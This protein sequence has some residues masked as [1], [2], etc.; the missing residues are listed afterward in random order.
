MSLID[1]LRA[2]Q[3]GPV[4]PDPSTL[5]VA[6]PWSSG[7]LSPVV[8]ADIFG[9][10]PPSNSRAAAMKLPPVARA[11]NL[12]VS[13]GCRI[14]LR[15]YAG[16]TQ[17]PD[18]D[19]PFLYRTGTA[20]TWQ[21]RNAWTIDDLIFYGWSLWIKTA[22][23]A[24]RFPLSADR[25]DR[26]AWAINSDNRVEINGSPVDDDKVILIPGL[27]EGILTY[28]VDAITDTREL[29]R[30][31]RDRI[32]NPIPAIDLHQTEGDDLPKPERDELIAGWKAARRAKGGAAVGYT[33]KAI[34]ARELGAG[35]G[36]D[37]LIEARNAAA[38]DLAR[39]VGV[40]ASRIDATA[41]KSSLNYETTAGRNQE[42]VDF[43]L[44]LYLTPISARLSMDDCVPRGS[45][46]AHDFTDFT[47]VDPSRTGPTMED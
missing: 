19:A 5:P 46:V 11:R 34:E 37:L 1:R 22:V 40:A 30:I 38:L 29:Y 10:T 47:A 36:N 4:L 39:V 15:A 3:A 2:P 42:L 6:S 25:V 12:I 13:T 8:A 26:A 35:A 7:D 14:P 41:P 32:E 45:R 18:G 31:V 33:N 44:A 20:T 24:A 21:H 43:D 9:T 16:E 23:D 28:G 17:R 27:H